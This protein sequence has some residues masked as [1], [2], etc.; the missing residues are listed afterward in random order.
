M[1]IQELRQM[2]EKKLHEKLIKTRRELNS[3]KFRAKAGQN[4]NTAQVTKLRKMIAKI[5]TILKEMTLNTNK[6]STK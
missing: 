6:T 5:M 2:T 3:S 1:K 4:Q